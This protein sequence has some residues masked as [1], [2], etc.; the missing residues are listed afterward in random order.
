ME[1][2]PYSAV[3]K[4]AYELV[5]KRYWL[6]IF[7]LFIA[8]TSGLNLGAINY[9]VAVPDNQFTKP[10]RN[11]MKLAFDW[12]S[13]NPAGFGW[14][15]AA[16][17]FVFLILL[18]AQG[19]AKSAVIWSADKLAEEAKGMIPKEKVDFRNSIKYGWRYVWRVVILQ[20]AV[21]W[22]F[23][24]ILLVFSAPIFYLFSHAAIGRAITLLLLGLVILIPAG[25]I[26]GFL[27]LYGPII[28]VL[29]NK[30][31]GD[32]LRIAFDL[33]R[34]KLAESIFLAAFIIG[35]NLMFI[36]GAGFGIILLAV[37]VALLAMLLQKFGYLFALYALVVISLIAAAVLVMLFK[38]AF[39]AFQNVAWV[40]AVKEMIHTV[41]LKDDA[42]VLATEPAEGT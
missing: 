8:G 38:G 15:V 31:V 26:L 29:Y 5:K 9:R 32:A 19:L 42:K 41:G 12:I 10:V 35:V 40:L 24:L 28:I 25:L 17:L 4:L 7:G 37:P 16:S 33:I 30:N 3:L 14:I 22:S 11:E 34:R 36:L 13:D 18:L 21:T 39:A 20:V 23:F 1:S 2:F 27:H 6:W